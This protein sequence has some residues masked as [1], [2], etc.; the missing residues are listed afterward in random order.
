[1]LAED[2][3]VLGH[4]HLKL[5]EDVKSGTTLEMPKYLIEVG[6]M[7]NSEILYV[8]LFWRLLVSTQCILASY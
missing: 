2:G 7:V 1:M 8:L 6:E 4:R 3:T 5:S